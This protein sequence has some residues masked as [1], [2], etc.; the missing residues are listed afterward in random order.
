M[1]E[2]HLEGTNVDDQEQE[3]ERDSPGV[4]RGFGMNSASAW[5]IKSG[6]Y[7]DD[8]DI[9]KETPKVFL[10]LADPETAKLSGSSKSAG[11]RTAL[12]REDRSPSLFCCFIIC[13]Y[14]SQNVLLCTAILLLVFQERNLRNVI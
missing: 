14:L 13:I 12:R 11:F 1:L 3:E 9:F 7:I 10:I 5:T 2:D 6:F 8:R 4:R